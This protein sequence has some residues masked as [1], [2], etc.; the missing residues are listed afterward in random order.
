M[1]MCVSTEKGDVICKSKEEI[2]E[3]IKQGAALPHG[4]E[5]WISGEGEKYPCLSVLV[6]GEYA[7]VHFFEDEEGDVW[8]SCGEF[9]EGVS[10]LA[11]GEAWDAPADV[12]IPMELALDAMEEFCDTMERPECICWQ[13]L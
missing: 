1:N 3:I 6:K 13:E 8:Q 2:A 10:F 9:G 12:I 7:C 5:M 11:G 4:G